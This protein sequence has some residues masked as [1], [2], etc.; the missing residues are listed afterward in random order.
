M[1]F[2][3]LN[4][5]RIGTLIGL[6]LNLGMG[7]AAGL[8]AWRV[9]KWGKGSG[10]NYLLIC[11]Q[12]IFVGELAKFL[13]AFTK[14]SFL[15]QIYPIE[16]RYVISIV[17]YLGQAIE[18]AGLI[19]FALY[20]VGFINGY[21]APPVNIFGDAKNVTSTMKDLESVASNKNEQT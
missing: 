6:I 12:F 17:N 13:S 15:D 21:T 10:V 2:A 3:E 1:E 19:I 20:I 4:T 5:E 7:L 9:T 16:M 8:T 11:M 18:A 14:I